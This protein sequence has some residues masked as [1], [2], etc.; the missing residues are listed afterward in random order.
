MKLVSIMKALRMYQSAPRI[1][2]TPKT[3]SLLV[4]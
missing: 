2:T 4:I 1:T 3:R